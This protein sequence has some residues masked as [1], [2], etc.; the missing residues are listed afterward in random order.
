VK[1]KELQKF[2]REIF[3]WYKLRMIHVPNCIVRSIGGKFINIVVDPGN[4]GCPDCLVFGPEG[5][6]IFGEI[7]TETGR[8][9][10]E[11]IEFQ[12]WCKENNHPYVVWRT[13]EEIEDAAKALAG[14]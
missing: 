7:K 11:Q 4:K 2:A 8:L 6:Y 3:K 5:R 9:S 12:T 14:G 10:P 13:K 1:E